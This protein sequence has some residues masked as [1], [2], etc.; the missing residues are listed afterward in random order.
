MSENILTAEI[1]A[2]RAKRMQLLKNTDWTQ[3]N[4]AP[5]SAEKKTKFAQYRQELR[6]ITESYTNPFDVVWPAKPA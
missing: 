6:D 2:V 1:A 5:L 3:L 4:D